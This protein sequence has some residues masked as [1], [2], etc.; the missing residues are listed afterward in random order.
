MGGAMRFPLAFDKMTGTGNDFIVIDNREQVV[1]VAEQA[2]LARKICRR[3][4]SVGADGVIFLESGSQADLQWQFYNP[5]GSEAE[6]CGNGARCAARFAYQHRMVAERKMTIATLA[7]VIGAEIGEDDLVRVTMPI[8]HDIRRGLSMVLDG[9]EW[10]AG[11]LNTGVP[12]LVLFVDDE[13]IPVMSWGRKLRFD[14]M[15]APGGTNVNFARVLPDGRLKVRTYERG[16]EAET[17]ACGTG[18][19][20]SALLAAFEQG[21]TSPVTVVTSGGEILTILFD[22]DDGSVVEKVFLQGPA[23][24]VYSGQLT[25]EALL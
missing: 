15:F 18:A 14:E 6:M 19:V 12:H 2:E 11:Y 8:P 17:M 5:D 25:P 10:L 20:A 22:L 3:M 7:G 24:L 1:L 23:R 13:P 21:L 9:E 16:V 4:F